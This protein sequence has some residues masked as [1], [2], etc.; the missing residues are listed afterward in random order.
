MTCARSLVRS[1]SEGQK[2]SGIQPVR[3]E[4]RCVAKGYHKCPFVVHEGEEFVAQRKHGTR[5][6]AFKVRMYVANWDIL[7]TCS[8]HR[9]GH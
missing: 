5:G 1:R 9:S 2:M 7:N 8:L 4:I 3:V 6:K